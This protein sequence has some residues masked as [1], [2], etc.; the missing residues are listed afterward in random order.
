M[1]GGAG[2]DAPHAARS[3]LKTVQ[4]REVRLAGTGEM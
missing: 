2:F 1:T 4:M 3:P